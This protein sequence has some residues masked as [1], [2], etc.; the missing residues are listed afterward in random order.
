MKQTAIYS[1][2]INY[3]IQAAF[4]SHY[5][6]YSITRGIMYVN[7]CKGLMHMSNEIKAHQC[8]ICKKDK[9]DGIFVFD[10]YIC[11][12]CQH[13]IINITPGD[14]KYEHYKECMRAIWDDH[15]E[16]A[17]ANI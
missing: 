4:E 13:D 8:F 6:Y 9:I 17:D 2:I 10:K 16:K 14:E 11:T 5:E 15:F 12:D 1:F 7:K 3:S